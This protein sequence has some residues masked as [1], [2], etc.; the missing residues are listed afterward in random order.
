MLIVFQSILWSVFGVII[1]REK[2]VNAD[3]PRLLGR[4]LYWIGVPLQI[5]FLARQANFEQIAWLPPVVT[6][7]GAIVGF[8][9]G[10]VYA[11]PVSAVII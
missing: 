10:L 8:S 7:T 9:I 5:F 2:I 6:D 11:A 1:Y 3:I 4:A